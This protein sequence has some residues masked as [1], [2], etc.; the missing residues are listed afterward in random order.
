M[1]DFDRSAAGFE[2]AKFG[3]L[4]T[5]IGPFNSAHRAMADVI[6]LL[7]LFSHRLP[8]GSTILGILLVNAERQLSAS[9]RW[10][11]RWSG[12]PRLMPVDTAEM[13]VCVGFFDIGED[14]CAEGEDGSAS[15]W[16]PTGSRRA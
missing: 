3:N 16:R 1:R 14:E 5:Q 10:A 15:T 8:D 11:P 9:R 7:H 2:G 12:D 13:R 6:T 4:L